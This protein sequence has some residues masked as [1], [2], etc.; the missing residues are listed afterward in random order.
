MEIALALLKKFWPYIV[1]AALGAAIGGKLAWSIQGYRIDSAKR[2]TAKVEAEFEQYK[3]EQIRL[4][5]ERERV[6]EKQRAEAAAT[7][8]QLKGELNDEIAKGEVFKRCVAAGRCGAVRVPIQS[9]SGSGIAAAPTTRLNATGE[10]PIP[11]AGKLAAPA[12]GEFEVVNDCAIA[13]LQLNRLQVFIE[14]QDG[15]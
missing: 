6:A 14:V 9:C 7:F 4:H 3:A 8:I 5:N 2:D 11:L 15:Y 12:S 13:T 1:A 10:N